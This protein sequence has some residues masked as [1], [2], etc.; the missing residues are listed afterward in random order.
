MDMPLL[1]AGV[2]FAAIRPRF[3]SIWSHDAAKSRSAEA[4]K[5]TVVAGQGCPGAATQSFAAKFLLGKRREDS[6]TRIAY[7]YGPDVSRMPAKGCYPLRGVLSI[8]RIVDRRS[9]GDH[10]ELRGKRI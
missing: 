1:S 5:V 8:L 3:A 4:G 9:R 2:N 7:L 10:K 6:T